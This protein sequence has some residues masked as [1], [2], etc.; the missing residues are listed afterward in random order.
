MGNKS[1]YEVA[2]CYGGRKGTDETAGQP[3]TTETTMSS[4]GTCSRNSFLRMVLSCSAVSFMAG[5]VHHEN[6]DLCT[7]LKVGVSESHISPREG[8]NRD[9]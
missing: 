3:T 2:L 9:K 1:S 5:K 4:T 6:R 8:G 7:C